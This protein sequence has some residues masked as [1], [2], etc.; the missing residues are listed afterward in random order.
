M[1]IDGGG[2]RIEGRGRSK[3]Q[4]HTEGE[5]L[6]GST[7]VSSSSKTNRTASESRYNGVESVEEKKPPEHDWAMWTY[8]V[9][10]LI[11]IVYLSV[12]IK[13]RE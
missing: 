4:N 7:S 2:Y 1:P 3:W 9:I 5:E 8:A 13:K 10:G 6:A 11:L 12:I